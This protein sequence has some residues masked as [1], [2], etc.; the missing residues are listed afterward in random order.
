MKMVTATLKTSLAIFLLATLASSTPLPLASATPLVLG[1][2]FP[3]ALALTHVDPAPPLHRA[4]ASTHG[5]IYP[6]PNTNTHLD[7]HFTAASLVTLVL[8]MLNDAYNSIV[9]H[10]L[11]NGDGL[12]AAGTWSFGQFNGLGRGFNVGV[13]VRNANNHQLTW[14]VIGSTVWGLSGFMHDRG[15]YGAVA[16]EVWD[17]VNMVGTGFLAI[18]PAG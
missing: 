3:N 14:G 13:S 1:Q 5:T 6:I 17:G 16:F 11:T 18:T 2:P 7:I 12:I 8:P 9:A 4:R 10:L 15:I